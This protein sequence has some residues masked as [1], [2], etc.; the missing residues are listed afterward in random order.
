MRIESLAPHKY[1]FQLIK[2]EPLYLKR[3][4]LLLILI[5]LGIVCHL[6][7][8]NPEILLFLILGYAC[9]TTGFLL[10][11][12]SPAKSTLSFKKQFFHSLISDNLKDIVM[13]VNNRNRKI[14]YANPAFYE[15]TGFMVESM[16]SIYLEDFMDINDLPQFGKPLQ[17]LDLQRTAIN[18]RPV[19]N[20]KKVLEIKKM[21]GES[22]WVEARTINITGE[23]KYALCH[24]TEVTEKV[25]L[26]RA[27][28]QFA[29]DLIQRKSSIN[30][31]KNREA[32]VIVMMNLEQSIMNS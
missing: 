18:V 26:E 11:Y 15:K 19:N 9:A 10:A 13:L 28:N 23:S 27:T 31:L 5:P 20:G 22:I 24:M 30:N 1:F 12:S 14:E 17:Y 32:E 8:W 7:N 16:E 2:E 21:N 25:K 6:Y 4:G 29:K 3:Y